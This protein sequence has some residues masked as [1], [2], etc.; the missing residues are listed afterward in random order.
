MLLRVYGLKR[1]A[2]LNTIS[3][4]INITPLAKDELNGP[5]GEDTAA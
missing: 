1:G 3:P 2:R 5:R 4:G